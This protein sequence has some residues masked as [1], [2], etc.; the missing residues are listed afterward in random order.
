[1]EERQKFTGREQFFARAQEIIGSDTFVKIIGTDGRVL[2]ERAF[3]EPRTNTE[4]VKNI[5]KFGISAVRSK[6]SPK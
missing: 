5:A 1:L 4:I 2:N 6:I 3:C